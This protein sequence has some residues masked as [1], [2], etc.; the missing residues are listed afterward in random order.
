QHVVARI[1]LL[2]TRY[3]E[4]QHANLGTSEITPNA[5]TV[6]FMIFPNFNMSLHDPYLT[7]VLKIQVQILGAPKTRDAIQATLHYN[8]AWRVQNYDRD[9]SLLGGQNSLFLNIDATNGT[10]QC[11]QIP[12][13]ILRK[14][15]VNDL[16]NA[17]VTK[18]EKLRVHPQHL[19]FDEPNLTI[20]KN[21]I[22]SHSPH[23][24]PNQIVL[25]IHMQQSQIDIPKDKDPYIISWFLSGFKCEHDL[26]RQFD[27]DGRGVQWFTFPFTGILH[28]T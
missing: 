5:A 10:T 2:D 8:L 15:L 23:K 27:Q 20:P 13:K 4:Y 3:Y 24:R 28:V 18:Y 25:T 17:W 6:F 26:I 22:L 14:E 11:T 7:E 12:S 16:P 19:F 1:S 21:D 9:L